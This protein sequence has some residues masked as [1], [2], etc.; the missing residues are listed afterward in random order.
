MVTP[1]A[2]RSR[3][4]SLRRGSFLCVRSALYPYGTLTTSPEI[5]SAMS[6]AS[7]VHRVSF[8]RGVAHRARSWRGRRRRG[9]ESQ[10]VS[11]RR[12]VDSSK[13]PFRVSRR[14]FRAHLRDGLEGFREGHRR[15][16]SRRGWTS[17]ASRRTRAGR[18]VGAA[19]E[20]ALE[21][22]ATT[23]P[24]TTRPTT[25]RPTTTRSTSNDHDVKPFIVCGRR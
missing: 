7:C 6:L 2:A 16:R 13:P 22:T 19:E 24:T 9:R 20:G 14:R 4:P 8:S 10:W 11:G 23:R 15:T 5:S 3:A 12:A 21:N 1:D 25:T 17:S 18:R